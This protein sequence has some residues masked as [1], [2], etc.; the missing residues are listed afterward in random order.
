MLFSPF[1]NV[2]AQVKLVIW[3]LDETLWKGT[4][5]EEGA[6]FIP[7]HLEMVRTLINRGIMCSICSKNDLQSARLALE[8]AGIWD[9]FVF[10]HIAW[11]P[12]G[13]AIATMIDDMGLRDE[14]V[15]FLD[16]NHLNIEEAIYFNPDIMTVNA[17]GVDLTGLLELPQLKGKDDNSHSRLAQYKAL[18]QK[19][20]GKSN[21]G[22]S[23][24]DFLRQSDIKIKIITDIDNNMDRVL[25]ILNRTN[26]LNFTKVRANTDDERAELKQLLGTSA[27]HA[28]LV[29]VQDRYGD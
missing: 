23:N 9:M 21:S 13:Q 20:A 6:Q 16:D 7:A 29:Q 11:S 8:D 10:P 15:L 5:S 28:G 25:E 4:L 3:D 26:Q 2:R 27:M 17:L 24:E 1:M 19:R 14:N 18:E 22:L 12:K